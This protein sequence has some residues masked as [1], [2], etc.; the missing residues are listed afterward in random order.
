MQ[1]FD[2]RR[3]ILL[4]TLLL[5]C[6]FYGAPR[7][8]LAQNVGIGTTTPQAE[9]DVNGTTRTTQLMMTGSS[10]TSGDVLTSDNAGT[11]SWT[12]PASLFTDTDDQDLSAS[13]AS[14]TV[15]IGITGGTG[16]SFSV[17]DED[18][19]AGNE[20]QDLGRSGTTLTISGGTNVDLAPILGD[21]LGNHTATQN[22]DLAGHSI[23]NTNEIESQGN[24]DMPHMVL[25]STNS[26]NLWTDQGAYVSIGESG[27]L[28]AASLHM[29]YRGD[30]FGFIGAGNVSNA[31]PGASYFRFDYNS[32]NIYTPDR[33]TIGGGARF[34]FGGPAN[35]YVL[36]ST[37][38]S[39]DATWT[40]P[41]GLSDAD[42]TRNASGYLTPTTSADNVGI[43]AAPGSNKL[44]VQGRTSLDGDVLVSSNNTSNSFYVT[45]YG[46][47]D[48]GLRAYASD[49]SL[50][51][52]YVEDAS[53]SS[54]GNWHFI[55]EQS[56]GPS[57]EFMTARPN[58]DVTFTAR[59]VGI[60]TTGPDRLLH[61]NSGQPEL[62]IEDSNGGGGRPGI[63]FIG[64]DLHFIEFDDNSTETIGFYSRFANSRTYDAQLRV[65]GSASGSWGVF[66]EISHDGSNAQLSTDEGYLN[67]D[68]SDNEHGIILRDFDGSGSAWSGIRTQDDGAMELR[69]DGGS[70][71]QLVLANNG[72]VGVNESNPDYRLDVN[73][74]SRT[75]WHGYDNR[76]AIL[77]TDFVADDDKLREAVRFNEND[78]FDGG[79]E[80]SPVNLGVRFGGGSPE[81]I[82]TIFIPQGYEAQGGQIYGSDTNNE[83]RFWSV[84]AVTGQ[85][86]YIGG[87]KNDMGDYVDFTDVSTANATSTITYILVYVG[88]G[89]GD[90]V[91]G[92]YLDLK[93]K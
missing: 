56:G 1:V 80:T 21:N 63:S 43:G 59:N 18:S 37:N 67:L 61:L 70:Y 36:T 66:T 22:L 65:H 13:K 48:Q 33:V 82:A 75:G 47:N 88:T 32:D 12:D 16:T 29:T 64:N 57:H 46:G 44:L 87:G 15:S 62:R 40:D 39:G 81:G 11:A 26:G 73:G 91:Y 84:N 14:N 71:D 93:R 49:R 4:L 20:L 38:G 52:R 69:A 68:P 51:T 41:A 3:T 42:W 92:G 30:G 58:G 45:R 19:D 76:L 34:D 35:G 74:D 27:A 86:D 53:E 78:L 28:G 60:G 2:P 17:A 25:S 9:L 72:N 31:E 89:G 8:G 6:L 23:R 55:N 79:P 10:P 85:G 24:A 77:P 83:V 50:Y 90:V 5:V 54:P 7:R